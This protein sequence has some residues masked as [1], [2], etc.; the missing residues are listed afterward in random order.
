M[1]HARACEK[2]ALSLLKPKQLAL[3]GPV[4]RYMGRQSHQ[5]LRREL[6]R[7]FAVDDGSDDIGR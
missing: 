4:D 3:F 5:F 1:H 7:V 2:R 6:R